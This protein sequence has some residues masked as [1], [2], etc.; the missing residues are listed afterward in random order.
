MKERL[1]T[2]PYHQANGTTSGGHGGVASQKF[3]V[4]PVAI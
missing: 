3:G 2:D 1:Q 4:G